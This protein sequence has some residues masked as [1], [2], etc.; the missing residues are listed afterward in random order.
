MNFS[1]EYHE[2]VIADDIPKLPKKVKSQIK[3]AIE[4]KLMT[5]PELFGKPLR[6]SLKNYRTL[7]VGDYR[8][9]FRIEK[10]VAKIFILQHRS[11]V[12][13]KAVARVLN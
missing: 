1:I 7:R 13:D 11:S 6:K 2:E 12:Y 5:R 10:R 8:V 9:I 4:D 3:K